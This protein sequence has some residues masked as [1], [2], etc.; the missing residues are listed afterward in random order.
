VFN[1]NTH[2][3]IL[4]TRG[5]VF[6]GRWSVTRI[7][8]LVTYNV[9]LP[10]K[11]VKRRTKYSIISDARTLGSNLDYSSVN[12]IAQQNGVRIS[13]MLIPLF[14]SVAVCVCMYVCVCKSRYYLVFLR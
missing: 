1:K 9:Q 8:S 5:L 2:F 12:K 11:A 10:N 3:S 7:W 6:D 4:S 13:N 14:E